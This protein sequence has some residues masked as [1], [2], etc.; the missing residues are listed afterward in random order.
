M[1]HD[2]V[3]HVAL[4]VRGEPVLPIK[5]LAWRLGV[6]EQ[7]RQPIKWVVVIAAQQDFFHGR[8]RARGRM[9]DGER[10]QAS[11]VLAVLSGSHPVK[12]ASSGW[13]T[14]SVAVTPASRRM[15]GGMSEGVICVLFISP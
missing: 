11:R 1:P 10:E 6:G 8:S 3:L 13:V 12:V 4:D 15:C 9:L 7:A 5:A 2:G 14:F